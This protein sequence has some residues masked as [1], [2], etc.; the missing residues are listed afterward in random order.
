[1]TRQEKQDLITQLGDLYNENQFV[2]LIQINS[3]NASDTLSFRAGMRSNNSHCIL[4]KNTLS[5]IAAKTAGL[6]N[7]NEYFS[8]QILT[9]FTNQPIEVAK[10]L[11]D[12]EA[13]GYS[14]IAG[15][16]KV[17]FFT[18]E[19]VK[20][21]A[22]VPAMPILRSMLLST[23]LGVHSKTVR[24][25]SESASSLARLISANSKNLTN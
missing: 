6:E 11:E 7:M 19:D 22:K 12:Y 1:M 10:L 9:I 18:A 4:A 21:L 14:V 13:K 8:K 16:D 2:F 24:V 15:S 20:K 23:I 25:L 5:K 17:N 3:V